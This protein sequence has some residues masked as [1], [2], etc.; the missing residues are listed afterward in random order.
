MKRPR[1]ALITGLSGQDGSY[2]AEFLLGKGYEVHGLVRRSSRDP[3]IRVGAHK[4]RIRVHYG[5][6][7][8]LG[9]LERTIKAADP[10]EIYNLA[11]QSDVG[12][13]FKC[14]EETHEIDYAGVG[15][16]V[17][18][19]MDH[20]PKIRIYQASTSE[21]FGATSPPQSE[22]SAFNPV[23]PYGIAKLRA[24]EDYVVGYREKYGLYICSGVLFNHE[25]PRRGEHFVTRKVTLSLAKI[26]HGLQEKL[27]LG[28]LEAR[29]D[30]GYAGDYVE[31]MWRML[32][33]KKPQDFVIATGKQHSVRELVDAAA[34]A[35]G[36]K[37]AWHGRGRRMVA[38][39]EQGRVRVA[40]DPRYFRPREVNSLLGDAR[41]ARRALGWKPEHSFGELIA[42]MAKADE[43]LIRRGKEVAGSIV[44]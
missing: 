36:M 11:A 18:A 42:M 20:N 4:H 12:I 39:D 24:H 9:A 25:S 38:K 15:R 37:L 23:S 43:E 16:L 13:S 21:M 44:S 35:L 30:W 29:R 17:H 7:R 2:L 22:R 8:D 41:K 27:M 28:N 10:H 33:Q 1:R 14:P 34:E 32:Q 3:L 40:V 6:L 5:D 19:A 31:A 26:K